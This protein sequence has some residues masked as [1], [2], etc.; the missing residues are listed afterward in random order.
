[1]SGQ[2]LKDAEVILRHLREKK[3][4]L[5]AHAFYPKQ[6]WRYHWARGNLWVALF[7]VEASAIEKEFLPYLKE[8]ISALK[9]YYFRGKGL[10]TLIDDP[11]SPF[12]SSATALFG[13]VLLR[14]KDLELGE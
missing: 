3:T 11:S 4:G 6:N 9:K 12:E 14:A 1:M 7:L 2:I 5:Y 8:E 13:Y 10:R